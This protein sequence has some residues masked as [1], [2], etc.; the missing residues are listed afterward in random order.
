MSRY[1]EA[2]EAQRGHYNDGYGP[3][4]S[5]TPN[6]YD[7]QTPYDPY[8]A[9]NQH[10]QTEPY[11]LS[12]PFHTPTSLTPTPVHDPYQPQHDAYSPH[13]VYPP[14]S[15]SAQASADYLGTQY[16]PFDAPSRSQSQFAPSYRGADENDEDGDF[17][18]LQ[19]ENPS[20]PIPM[21]GGYAE[22][23][24]IDDQPESNIRYG[25]IPQRV[26]RRYK[27]L[28]KVELFHGNLVLDSAVPSK[29]LDMSAVRNEREFTHM[30]YSAATCDPNDFKDSG[31]TLR[32]V[33]YD[34]PRRTELFIVMTMYN[35]SEDLFCRSMHGVIKN[36]AHLCKRDRSKTWGKDGWKK[37]V[38]CIVSDGRQKINSRT[39]SVI[40]TMGAYQDGIAKNVVNGKPV[41]AHIYEYT[42]QISVT[43]SMKIEGAEKG[44][45]PVQIIF[46]LKEKNQ[47]KI[48]SHRWFF[49][50]FG[51]ILQPNVC[52]L[53]DVG[54]MPGPTSIYH[55]WKAFDINS[56]VGG[57]CGEIVALKGK[58]G[59][60]L[61]NPLVAAQNFE[62]KMSNILDKPLESVFGY[63]TVLPGA[64]SAYRYIALQNDTMGEG[65]L[66]K[67]FLGEKMHGAGADIFTANMYLA[68]DRIL[69][70]ELVSKRGG[71]WILH[72]VKS[73]YAVT[74]VPDQ[75]P[76]LISQ[77]RRW[78]NGSFFAAIHSI[79]HF[80]YIYRSSHTFMR[81]FWIHVE[82]FYQVY[83]L[84]FAWFSL[85]NYY[86]AFVI[87]SNALESYVPSLHIPNLVLNYFYLGL[88]IMCFLLSLGNRPQGSKWGYTLAF[89]GFGVVTIYMTFSAFYIAVK[90][91]QEVAADNGSININ[92]LFS[93]PIFINIVLSLAATL[94]L[95]IA[96]SLIFFEPWHMITSFVQYLLMAPSYIAVLNVYAF[97]NVH[98]VSWGTKGDHKV[99]TDLG[100]V[101]VGKNTNEVE[102]AVPTAETD[103]NAAYEDAILVLSSKPPKE[104]QK[105][106]P[107]TKQEDYYKTFRTN[108]LL[109]WTLSNGLLA[110]VV[111]ASTPAPN[112]GQVSKSVNG[113]MAFI[114]FSVVGLA[115]VRF[116]GSTVYM[117][118]RLFA[119]E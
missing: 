7:Q 12:D 95:Y 20:R 13:G 99:S 62:Y 68:E 59:Q 38:V 25:R 58:Y 9:Q 36:V 78:L 10:H 23:A 2:D 53:L 77:R 52:V 64:F 102:V 112:S 96:A 87:L 29:L 103:I 1:P 40:A 46:C 57:A 76:E 27:T 80:H 61:I 69:C 22:V 91:I 108:V 39:L 109:V 100:V 94:G 31:F 44:V 105:V 65:P 114:L 92:D 35:E 83:N 42:T 49:N 82:M 85:G 6:P 18:L 72:Y 17:P 28:K 97:A 79:V 26:P 55:L 21:P 16:N 75:V 119:G 84:I 63:I 11:H 56:N 5:H 30:R 47:K 93:N 88:L 45:I 90:G 32:Q 118:V 81:K 66:Q 4:P 51:P 73:A 117:L 15:Q 41:T 19:R 67:Y 24:S 110:A 101:S 71:S 86:I 115:F 60:Y 70:W 107:A 14:H 104:E 8:G 106:D 50:A 33:H 37:V 116:L 113:Y 48:N 34:P 89:I 43:P 54:T 111:V 74:D 3:Y 98:D